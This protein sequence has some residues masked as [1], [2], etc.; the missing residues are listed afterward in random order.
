MVQGLVFFLCGQ[1]VSLFIV[2][3]ASFEL[4]TAVQS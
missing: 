2:L 1:F 4:D 3:D